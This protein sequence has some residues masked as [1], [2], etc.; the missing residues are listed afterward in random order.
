[1]GSIENDVSWVAA[2]RKGIAGFVAGAGGVLAFLAANQQLGA[3][4]QY[5][6]LAL[7]VLGAAGV[8]RVPNATG[9]EPATRAP[10]PGRHPA[11][12]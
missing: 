3:V 4:A 6:G 5:A 8:Y 9:N 10:A 1:M 11:G 7:A 2:H 12:S